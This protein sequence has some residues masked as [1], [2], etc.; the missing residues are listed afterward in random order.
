MP[1]QQ[2]Q[3]TECKKHMT[4]SSQTIAKLTGSY[5]N[6][7]LQFSSFFQR[8]PKICLITIISVTPN[9]T[10]CSTVIDQVSLPHITSYW[11]YISIGAMPQYIKKMA[12]K[13]L[14]E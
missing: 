6:K 5:P 12:R 1:N 13:V 8:D 14:I 4:Q 3:S 9:F 10:S 7:S 2:C 11:Q